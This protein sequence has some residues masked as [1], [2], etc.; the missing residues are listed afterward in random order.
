M[1]MAVLGLLFSSAVRAAGAVPLP[2]DSLWTLQEFCDHAAGD[3]P[4]DLSRVRLLSPNALQ[5]RDAPPSVRDDVALGFDRVLCHRSF[6]LRDARGSG[7]LLWHGGDAVALRLR[8]EPVDACLLDE[9]GAGR[10]RVETQED[11][12]ALLSVVDWAAASLRPD[13]TLR[14]LD[15]ELLGYMTPF[16]G[17]IYG[18]RGGWGGALL[19]N[20][21]RL[22]ALHGEI[23]DRALLCLLDA[24]NPASRAAGWELFLRDPERHAAVSREVARKVEALRGAWPTVQAMNGCFLEELDLEEAV[25]LVIQ[26][27]AVDGGPPED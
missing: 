18:V 4:L 21:A 23:D 7:E 16:S 15:E 1:A 13:S 22:A 17:T 5:G 25:R 12:G 27:F 2:D 8:L 9:A 11:G 6:F 20:R 14:G 10:L 24:V 26:G 3:G 19:Q